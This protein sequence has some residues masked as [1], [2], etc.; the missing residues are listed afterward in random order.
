M[1]GRHVLFSSDFLLDFFYFLPPVFIRV[2]A[3]T[4]AAGI[5]KLHGHILAYFNAMSSGAGRTGT[6]LA[7]WSKGP[8]RS[9]KN[10][11]YIAF[12]TTIV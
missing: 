11:L 12:V 2:R 7:K 4:Q 3:C 1:G 5:E 9:K 10:E 6:L 8:D